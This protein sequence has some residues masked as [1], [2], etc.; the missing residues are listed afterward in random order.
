MAESANILQA[1]PKERLRAL[2][3]PREH[4]AWG[5]MLIPL[6]TGAA[7]GLARGRAI[8]PLV[9]FSCLALLL[10]WLRTPVESLL[11]TSPMRAQTMAERAYVLRR[12]VALV[13]IS[14]LC[15]AALLLPGHYPDLLLLGAAVSGAFVLQALLRRLGRA[16]RMASQL[17][18]AAGL[19]ATAPAAYYVV[20]GDFGSMVWGLWIANWLFAGNQI[21]F[22]Q[23]RIHAAREVGL[24]SRLRRGASFLL[25]HLFLLAGL[26]VA[27]RGHWLPAVAGLVFAP[28]V[29]RGLLWFFQSPQ[30]LAVRRL[31]WT[32]MVQALVFGCLLVAALLWT[33]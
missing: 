33:R 23:L 19:T 28:A 13:A 10:F 2:V 12:V 6:L 18:G 1:V 24:R 7:V 16:T 15:L 22:V 11:G 29:F 21:H 8:L 3:V 26:F 31:G 9:L 4:G 20:T 5:M 25:G 32:E 17:I 30:P 14:V 27:Y